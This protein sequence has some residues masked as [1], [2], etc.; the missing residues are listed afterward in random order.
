MDMALLTMD[1]RY[2]MVQQ[3][4]LQTL[5]VEF[6]SRVYP[7][8]P[9]V[10]KLEAWAAALEYLTAKMHRRTISYHEVASLYGASITTIS[11]CV[12]SMDEACGIRE[13]MDAIFPK[14]H[15]KL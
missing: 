1:K 9:K 2:D 10:Q 11:K 7:N 12:K 8:V 6:L 3:H 5:W 4:D 15:E 13:K 14:F